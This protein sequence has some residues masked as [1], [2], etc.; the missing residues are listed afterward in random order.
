MND[1]HIDNATTVPN[2]IAPVDKSIVHSSI[3]QTLQIQYHLPEDAAVGTVEIEIEVVSGKSPI[4][5][6]KT[7]LL[8]SQR[9]AV[10]KPLYLKGNHNLT[11]DLTTNVSHTIDGGG[12]ENENGNKNSGTF[13]FCWC[14]Q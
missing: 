5:A 9:V 13:I 2:I 12:N 14:L 3:L 4:E 6:P 1:I 11:L 10:L 8:S 7:L